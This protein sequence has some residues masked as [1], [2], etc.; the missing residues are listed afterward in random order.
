MK[1]LLYYPFLLALIVAGIGLIETYRKKQWIWAI[2]AFLYAIGI[3]ASVVFFLLENIEKG[4]GITKFLLQGLNVSLYI[5]LGFCVVLLIGWFAA[6]RAFYPWLLT[7]LL[8]LGYVG[9][10]FLLRIYF[11]S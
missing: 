11:L 8:C 4:R 6:K 2:V 1:F 7:L 3:T 5:T 9:V 10:Y